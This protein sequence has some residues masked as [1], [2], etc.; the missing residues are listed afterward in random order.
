MVTK[1]ANPLMNIRGK[2]VNFGPEAINEIYG[3]QNHGFEKFM[4]KDYTPGSWLVSKLCP[5]KKVPWANTKSEIISTEFTAE[6]RNWISNVCSRVSPCGN[7]SC[8]PVLRAQ[9]VACILDDIPLNV[10]NLIVNCKDMTPGI[11]QPQKLALQVHIRKPICH[12]STDVG[13][14]NTPLHAQASTGA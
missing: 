10:G 13:L 6:S 5:S 3:L 12:P 4:E 7:T 14:L 1:L 8:I 11:T 2:V 9:I